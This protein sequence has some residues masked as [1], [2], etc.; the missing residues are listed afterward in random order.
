MRKTF[1][2]GEV[3][4][5]ESETYINEPFCYS[6]LQCFLVLISY[7][8]RSGGG[9]GDLLPL[10]SYK[11][12]KKFFIWRFIYDLTF[13]I[14]II[15]IMGNVTFG[16]IVDTFGALRDNTY[17]Y[18]EDRENKCFICQLSRD[19]CLIK[20]IDYETHIKEEHN[21]WSY[22]DFLVYL[23]LYNANDFTRIEGEVWDKLPERDYGWIPMGQEDVEDEEED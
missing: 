17:K 3:F 22:V 6:S 10:I 15:M 9:I 12:D 4:H 23:H 11:Y 19:G 8:T 14:I 18:E 21:L 7:G 2:L 5:Y 1:D 13:G 20:N 16:L